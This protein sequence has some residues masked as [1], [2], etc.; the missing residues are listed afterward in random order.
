MLFFLRQVFRLCL[1]LQTE[2]STLSFR[3]VILKNECANDANL[4]IIPA[5]NPIGHLLLNILVGN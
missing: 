3:A 5:Y 4:S 1:I 2:Q